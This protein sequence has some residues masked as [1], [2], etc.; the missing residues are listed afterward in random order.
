[1]D[2]NAFGAVFILILLKTHT[3]FKYAKLSELARINPSGKK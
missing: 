2:G 3:L 1:M